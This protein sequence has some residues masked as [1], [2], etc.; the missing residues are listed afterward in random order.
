[1][2]TD[3]KGYRRKLLRCMRKHSTMV[4]YPL[5]SQHCWVM[6]SV[7]LAVIVFDFVLAMFTY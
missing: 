1:M 7:S 3:G 5:M 2:M 4:S 6:E